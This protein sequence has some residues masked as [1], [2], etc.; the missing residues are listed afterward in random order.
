VANQPQYMSFNI[1]YELI[2]ALPVS[3]METSKSVSSWRLPPPFPSGKSWSRRGWNMLEHTVPIEISK[4]RPRWQFVAKKLQT[5]SVSL[6]WNPRACTRKNYCTRVQARRQATTVLRGRKL[7]LTLS[8][9]LQFHIRRIGHCRILRVLFKNILHYRTRR[10]RWVA[11][12]SLFEEHREGLT[13]LWAKDGRISKLK[14][15]GGKCSRRPSA[16]CF[17]SRSQVTVMGHG[18]QLLFPLLSVQITP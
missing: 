16:L 13:T 15:T 4:L 9:S 10:V 11:G 3:V 14:L 8:T 6:V 17:G 2:E 1:L 7:R 5:Q 12:A 18:L